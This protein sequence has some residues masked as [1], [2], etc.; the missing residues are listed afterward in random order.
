VTLR[1]KTYNHRKLRS[2]WSHWNK[3]GLKVVVVGKAFT[4]NGVG[5]YLDLKW[6][7]S[8]ERRLNAS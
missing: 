4:E 1:Q 6:K 7:P 2:V 5:L 8:C 3:T